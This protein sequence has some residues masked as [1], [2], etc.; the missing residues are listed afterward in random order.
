MFKTDVLIVGSGPAGS[1]AAL[2]CSSYGLDNMVVTKHRWLAD[3]PRAH[4]KNQR[5]MEIMRDLGIADQVIAQASPK[6]VMGNVVFCTSLVGEELGRLPYGANQPKRHSD[7]ALASPCEHC[8]LPQHLLE[9]ILLSNAA[10]RG[11]HVRFDTEYLSHV[12]DIDG[13][14]VQVKDRLTQTT[15]TIRAKY[16]LGADGGNSKV[17][18]DLQLPMEGQMGLAGSIS[19]ILHADLSVFVAHRPGYLWWILQPGCNIGGIGMG[20]LRMVR[21]WNE[22]QIVWGYDIQAGAPKLSEDDAKRIAR[23]LIGD[24]TIPITIRSIST[25]TVNQ[26]YA[27]RYSKDRIFCLGDAVHRHPPSNGLG[28]NSSIQDAY[29]LT[30]KLAFVLKG[31]ASPSL[32]ETYNAE[33][34]PIGKQIVARANKSIGEFAPILDALGLSEAADAAQMQTN[35]AELKSDTAKGSFRRDQLRQAIAFKSYEFA[36]Q[37]VEMNQHYRSAAIIGESLEPEWPRDP[38]LYYQPST[39]SG[40]R[41]PHAWLNQNGTEISTLDL[42]GKGAFTLLTGIGGE[43][44][45]EAAISIEAEFR[46]PIK[47]YVIG[48][49]RDV[50]DLYG[51]WTEIRDIPESGCILVRPDGHIAWR[52]HLCEAPQEQ[53]TQ[54]LG[55]LLDWPTIAS[56]GV[57]AN[58]T[59]KV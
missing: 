34:V 27:T 17:A 11:S 13:V 29:N 4:Y 3:S 37:G 50:Q 36:T 5:T 21:P 28:S 35:M 59:A 32:L 26:Q 54:I 47:A 2:M 33:R 55:R 9:P 6:A 23:Q 31:L 56:E 16:L 7:Y 49:G 39:L 12:Q 19:I 8:D 1:S 30:W 46:V 43:R 52:S 53:L 38:E 18:T 48:P 10:V 25:W 24:E 51:D 14:T 41:L 20:L 22:W 42:V 40:G 15:Y 58:A 57:H 45:Q 44:W